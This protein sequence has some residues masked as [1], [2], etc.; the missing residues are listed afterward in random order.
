[1]K[2]NG[3]PGILLGSCFYIENTKSRVQRSEIEFSMSV[4][5][6]SIHVQNNRNQNLNGISGEQSQ[7]FLQVSD[8]QEP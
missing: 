7:S 8:H 3:L 5:T 4:Q 6:D 1:M 2:I